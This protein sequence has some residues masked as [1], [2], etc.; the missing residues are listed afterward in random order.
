MRIIIVDDNE[1]LSKALKIS[2]ETKGYAVDSFT[3]SVKAQKHLLMN[4]QDYDLIILDWAMPNITGFDLCQKL[5]SCNIRTPILMLTAVK[6]LD[7]KV[8]VLD[9]GADDYLTKPFLMPELFAR[10]RALLRRPKEVKPTVITIGDISINTSSRKVIVAKKEV[11]LTLKEF[12]I[13]EYL[14]INHDQVIERDRILDHVWDM[15]FVS[16]SNIVDVRINGL[17]KKMGKSKSSIKTIWGVGY[18]LEYQRA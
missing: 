12:G 3:D 16:L 13:L 14:M 11:D 4:N 6:E 9:A 18:K 7:T 8:A 17:R 2:L 15:G 1:A 10:I 5:R